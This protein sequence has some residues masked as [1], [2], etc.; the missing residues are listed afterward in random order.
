MKHYR[1]DMR[2]AAALRAARMAQPIDLSRNEWEEI[3]ATSKPSDANS[4]VRTIASFW[5]LVAVVLALIVA[6]PAVK[7]AALHLI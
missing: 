2:R 1:H 5:L 3:A 7:A 4:H 6:A